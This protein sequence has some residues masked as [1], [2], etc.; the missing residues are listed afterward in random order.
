M[1]C[2]PFPRHH[3]KAVGLFRYFCRFLGLAVF[4]GINAGRNLLAGLTPSFRMAGTEDGPSYFTFFYPG[5]VL[6][7]LLFDSGMRSPTELLNVTV[8][9]LDPACKKLRIGSETSKTFGRTINLMLCSELHLYHHGWL[10]RLAR[11][12]N[13]HNASIEE[14][15]K[16]I[17][18]PSWT[19]FM[20]SVRMGYGRRVRRTTMSTCPS[21]RLRSWAIRWPA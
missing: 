2:V 7:M 16:S 15:V 20:G 10:S 8:G 9:D 14:G 13:N 12:A 3:F 21:R 5:V 4:A 1:F 19:E 11:L 17:R 18:D 6:M